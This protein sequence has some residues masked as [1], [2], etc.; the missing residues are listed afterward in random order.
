[1]N[2]RETGIKGNRQ[3]VEIVKVD[4]RWSLNANAQSNPMHSADER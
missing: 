3:G 1:M 2:E 4:F